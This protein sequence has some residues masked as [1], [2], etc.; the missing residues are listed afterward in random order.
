MRVIEQPRAYGQRT[1]TTLDRSWRGPWGPNR[2]GVLT[3]RPMVSPDWGVQRLSGGTLMW[4]PIVW[5]EIP[6]QSCPGRNHS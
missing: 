2:A 4:A 5:A 3:M 6:L 1:R